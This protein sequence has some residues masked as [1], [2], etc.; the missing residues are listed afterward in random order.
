MRF[1]V[2]QT[3]IFTIHSF[4]MRESNGFFSEWTDGACAMCNVRIATYL[5]L[6]FI[7]TRTHLCSRSAH[8]IVKRAHIQREEERKITKNDEK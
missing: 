8:D 2:K 5:I 3:A 7:H 4:Q 6:V 1:N